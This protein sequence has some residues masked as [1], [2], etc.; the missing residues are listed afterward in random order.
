MHPLTR[1]SAMGRE[2][3]QA[4]S[5]LVCPVHARRVGGWREAV[6]WHPGLHRQASAVAPFCSHFEH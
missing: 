6:A 4:Q 1:A 2:Q 3:S 5:Q